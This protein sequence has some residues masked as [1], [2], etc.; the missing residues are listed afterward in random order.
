VRREEAAVLLYDRDCGFCV[1]S[2]ELIRAWDR[3]GRIA[4]A[5]I[6]SDEGVRFL[7]RMTPAERLRSMHVVT[8]EGAVHSGSAGIPALLRL[9]PAGRPLA[10]LGEAMPASTERAYRWV[11]RHRGRLGRVLGRR[12]C[13][14]AAS[15]Q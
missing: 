8:P 12:S 6:Q 15:A 3:V 1:W 5:P 10:H 9:L 14:T 2:A 4:I 11:S 7:A 13:D